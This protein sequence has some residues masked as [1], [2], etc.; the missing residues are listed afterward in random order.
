MAVP[1]RDYN[2]SNLPQ[3]VDK[4]YAKAL[5]KQ[6]KEKKKYERSIGEVFLMGLIIALVIMAIYIL[7][8]NSWE[9]ITNAATNIIN[10]INGLLG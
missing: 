3:R 4:K 2:Y 1:Q 6:L 7:Y 5:K 10:S 9:D 8:N